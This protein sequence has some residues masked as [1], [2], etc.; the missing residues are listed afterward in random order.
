[1]QKGYVSEMFASFQG[2][3]LFAGRRHAFLR[4]AACNLRCVYCDTP[5]SLVRTP[6]CSVEAEDGS[7]HRVQ[8]PLEVPET[9]DLLEELLRSRTGLHALAITGGEPLLQSEFLA[10]LLEC[11]SP[12]LPVLLETNGTY[13]E[14]LKAV[15]PFIDIVSMDVKLPSNSGE[16]PF[17]NEHREFLEASRGKTVYVKVPVDET[18]ADEDVERA[19]SLVRDV[20]GDAPFFLQPILSA[21]ARMRISPARLER[22]YDVATR[23]LADVRVLPQAH[24]FLG[25]R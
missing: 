8:N 15:L 19:A 6:T 10:E 1:V 2:E 5:E 17:W 4:M 18:T 9:A 7:E 16:R 22:M 25:V 3:G 23:R 13:P 20:D 11:F 21:D 12:R 24:R 14:R